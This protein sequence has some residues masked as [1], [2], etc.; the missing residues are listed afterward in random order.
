MIQS[1]VCWMLLVFTPHLLV[2]ATSKAQSVS[3]STL[4]RLQSP[5]PLERA[6]AFGELSSIPGAFD[7]PAITDRLLKLLIQENEL[8]DA[9]WA[10]GEA[11][12]T[13]Y[14]EGYAAYYSELLETVDR[15]ADKEKPGV[16]EIIAR[17]TYSTG[18]DSALLLATEYATRILP[19]M[20]EGAKSPLSFRRSQC[21]RMLI[22]IALNGSDL[23]TTDEAS[24]LSTIR[25]AVDDE[26]YSPRSAVVGALGRIG[27]L[28]D[29]P[30]L[31]QI[32]AE[33][34][35]ELIRVRAGESISNI[36]RRNPPWHQ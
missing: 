3:A 17:G 14:G 25:A 2:F 36:R 15:I 1:V 30:L 18:W 32:A 24:I 27:G 6:D 22:L 26:N 12:G 34:E 5:L 23:S 33:D 16:A 13:R 31:E 21:I 7:A 29:L 8:F 9:S 10:D 19:I 35:S 20:L 4:S 11:V 28:E